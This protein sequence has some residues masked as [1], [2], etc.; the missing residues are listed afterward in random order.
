MCKEWD[1]EENF[2]VQLLKDKSPHT[3]KFNIFLITNKTDSVPIQ[4]QIDSSAISNG[5][6][7]NNL[8]SHSLN[9]NLNLN[10]PNNHLSKKLIKNEKEA[11]FLNLSGV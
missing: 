8:S 10:G 3:T 4:T 2:K 11:N 7:H 1:I 9:S 6:I 5:I